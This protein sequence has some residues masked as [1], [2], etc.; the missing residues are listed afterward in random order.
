MGIY[1]KELNLKKDKLLKKFDDNTEKQLAKYE[2]VDNA[3]NIYLKE[4]EEKTEQE[5]DIHYWNLR[6]ID[7]LYKQQIEQLNCVSKATSFLKNVPEL[8]AF[9]SNNLYLKQQYKASFQ[10]PHNLK[11]EKIFKYQKN[12]LKILFSL[13]KRN[14]KTIINIRKKINKE[15]DQDNTK[16][17]ELLESHL[18]ISENLEYMS[19][20]FLNSEIP[21]FKSLKQVNKQEPSSPLN[22][23]DKILL[24]S[25]NE[26]KRINKIN[27]QL[28]DQDYYLNE[29]KVNIK[30]EINRFNLQN[31]LINSTYS[32]EMFHS[33]FDFHGK[34]IK[35][36]LNNAESKK[37]YLERRI[38]E[39]I[40]LED[41]IDDKHNFI[42][43]KKE[44][45]V[46]KRISSLNIKLK[47]QKEKM[48]FYNESIL[49]NIEN[50]IYELENK[51]KTT[52]N[53]SEQLEN[54]KNYNRLKL[55]E[56]FYD[57]NDENILKII[58]LK[59]SFGG[60]QVIKDLSFD[61]KKGEIFGLIGP[62]GAGK[63]TIFNLITQFYKPDFGEILFKNHNNEV[64]DL[65]EFKPHDVIEHGISRT[66][67]NIELI[68]ELTVL[69]N[70][71]V[72]AHKLYRTNLFKQMFRTKSLIEEEKVIKQKAL[73]MLEEFGLTEYK[74]S[75]PKGLPYGILKNVEFARTLMLNPD[76]IILDEPAA[77]LN[78]A[79]TKELT[80]FI[81]NVRDKYDVT[82]LLVEHDID[83]VMNVCDRV[84]VIN[85]G[86][87][88]ITDI[89]SVVKSNK[90]VQEAYIGVDVDA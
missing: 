61:V 34:K 45:N 44:K 6:R 38:S 75:Y 31:E 57:V 49:K 36:E 7:N 13:N 80:E 73:D 85:F 50:K 46:E 68:T 60:L 41:K 78:E 37:S 90:H 64:I 54:K 52:S 24:I 1:K 35:T 17:Y 71:L 83:L 30:E 21:N 28:K 59:M 22:I 10:L 11:N 88:I 2:F 5:N 55:M 4:K 19:F 18:I 3:K 67:Q 9:F 23:F 76:L 20:L 8:I 53:L 42:Y 27:E 79:E 70:L 65:K 62:N 29:N 26:E 33:W 40:S 63:T 89:P 66:F 39:R 25:Q 12:V 51:I 69:E 56:S 58:N 84:C 87:H 77:G 48:S 47:K 82:I 86:E 81:K 32:D 43:D 16:M 14:R 15:K 72:G 74:D